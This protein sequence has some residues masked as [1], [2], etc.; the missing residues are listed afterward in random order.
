MLFDG[1]IEIFT[2]VEAIGVIG[3]IGLIGILFR[4]QL[5][6]GFGYVVLVLSNMEAKIENNMAKP[7][8]NQ[9]HHGA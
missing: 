9:I 5:G 6:L 7:N 2:G 1:K 3:L 4:L 8:I